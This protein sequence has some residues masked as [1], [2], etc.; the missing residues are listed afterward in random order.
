D[1]ACGTMNFGIVAV[2]MLAAMYREECA[3]AGDAG[4]P[5][6][7]SIHDPAAA[8]HEAIRRN[9]YGI[10]IDPEALRLAK[11]T[12]EIVARRPLFAVDVNLRL[13]DALLGRSPAPW[14]EPFHVIV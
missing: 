6:T 9:L 13:G 11:M 4:W 1:P 5:P 8:E 3:R 10:D 2:Q 14:R 12:L 7:P